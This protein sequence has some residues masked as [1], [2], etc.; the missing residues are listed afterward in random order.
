MK[1]AAY[2]LLILQA[3]AI[4]LLLIGCAPTTFQLGDEVQPPPGCI[5]LR[6]RGGQ[7]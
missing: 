4:G 6:T 2:F 3:F 1:L 5:D 7:C